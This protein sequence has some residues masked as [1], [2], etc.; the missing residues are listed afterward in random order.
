MWHVTRG[1]RVIF[2]TYIVRLTSVSPYFSTSTPLG[3]LIHWHRKTRNYHSVVEFPYLLNNSKVFCC[4]PTVHCQHQS[5]CYYFGSQIFRPLP[6]CRMSYDG[7]DITWLDGPRGNLFIVS[8]C[9]VPRFVRSS[10]LNH[11]VNRSLCYLT[12]LFFVRLLLLDRMISKCSL[13]ISSW[14]RML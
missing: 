11:V 8:S 10:S 12:I 7:R 2:I 14:C 5:L 6:W 9:L 13:I 4:P 1:P 3:W